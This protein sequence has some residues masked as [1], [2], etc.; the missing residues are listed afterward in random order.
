[1]WVHLTYRSKL[2]PVEKCKKLHLLLTFFYY[3]VLQDK[4][5]CHFLT[6]F[7]FVFLKQ[8]ERESVF[9]ENC[10]S[11]Q[12]SLGRFYCLHILQQSLEHLLLVGAVVLWI[13]KIFKLIIAQSTTRNQKLYH[14]RQS[15]KLSLFLHSLLNVV[16]LMK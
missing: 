9:F 15:K 2:N 8:N 3:L 4:S 1:M 13:L 11:F 5:L 12:R 16:G 7:V 14:F 6:I 10:G